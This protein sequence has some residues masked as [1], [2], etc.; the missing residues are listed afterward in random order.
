M[1]QPI[2]HNSTQTPLLITK[3]IHQRVL[4]PLKLEISPALK[5]KMP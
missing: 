3:L 4:G 1:Y 5:T 2:F